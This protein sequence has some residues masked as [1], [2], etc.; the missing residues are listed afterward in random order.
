LFVKCFNSIIQIKYFLKAIFNNLGKR[1]NN[2]K[3]K[4][5][6]SITSYSIKNMFILKVLM[7]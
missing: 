7:K 2:E 6:G 3:S 5:Y 4:N 1:F